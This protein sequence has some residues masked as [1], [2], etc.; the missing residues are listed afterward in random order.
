MPLRKWRCGVKVLR[1]IEHKEVTHETL[2]EKWLTVRGERY[3][4]DD[5]I[6]FSF[7]KSKE[8]EKVAIRY[9]NANGGTVDNPKFDPED[10]E[11]RKQH[12]IYAAY[13]PIGVGVAHKVLFQ[14][15]EK[16]RAP[17]I[18]SMTED[19]DKPNMPY[20]P[21]GFG[22]I[23]R[24]WK[25][26]ITYAGT[27]DDAWIKEKHP[28]MPDDYKEQYNNA[29]HPDLQLKSYFEP[30]D[31]IVLHNLIKDRYQQSFELP[32]FHFKGTTETFFKPQEFYLNIDTVIVDVLEDD[33][34]KNAVY[35]SYRT[36]IPSSKSIEECKLNMIVPQDYLG[37]THG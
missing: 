2:V 17:Q 15:N 21:Q 3:I 8:S 22:C 1:P 37:A 23:G 20:V 4:Q 13:N 28:I 16:L 32:N 24:S 27:F 29:A 14:K 7:T 31:K 9:E 10:K 33:M 18:E 11:V 6:G 30:H 26:R 34:K 36:R 5:V 25:P 19:L 35:V 12:L